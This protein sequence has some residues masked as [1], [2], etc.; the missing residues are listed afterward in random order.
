MPDA[1]PYAR[2]RAVA[3]AAARAA[4]ALIRR[5]AGALGP[6]TVRD[7]GLHDLVTFVDEEAQ[8]L[9]TG[10]LR[11]AFPADAVLAEEGADERAAPVGG[12]RRWIVDPLDGTTNFTRGVPPYA[13]SIALQ[14]GPELVLGVVFDVAHDELFMAERGQGLLLD[15]RPAAVS[16]TGTLGASLLATGF[17][18]RDYRYVEGYLETFEALMRTATGLRR[19]G[20]ASVDLAWVACGRFDGFFEAGLAPWD[21]AAGCVLVAEGGGRVTGLPEGANPVFSGSLVASNGRLHAAMTAAAAPLA[22]AYA[23]AGGR[24]V[25]NT[26]GAPADT[27]GVRRA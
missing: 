4:G 20:A 26:P 16:R 18:F 14:D 15:G 24:V 22:A 7:K 23:A 19:H 2:E 12:G 9:I 27:G 17:P 13:V 21:V 6:G 5:H 8:R 11:A 3:E 25:F 10:H 1:T